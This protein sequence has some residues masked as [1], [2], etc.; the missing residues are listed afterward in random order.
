MDGLTI[1]LSIHRSIDLSLHG[2]RRFVILSAL[3]AFLLGAACSRPAPPKTF[4]LTGQVLSVD[5][6]KQLVTIRHEDIDGLMPGM[7]MSFPVTKP[8]LLD[9]REPGELVRGTLE[10]TDA[11][12]RLTTIERTGMSELPT[13]SNAA[14]MAGNLLDVG[15]TV[16]DAAFIDQANKRRSIAEWRGTATLMTFIYTQCPLPN[17][18]P[19][20]DQNF[21][22]LQT[23]IAGDV[24]LK[25]KAR[26]VSISFDPD[27]DT[28]DVLARHAARLQADPATWTFLTGDRATV[29]RFAARMGVGVM[30]EAGDPT[31]T[32]NL[33][34]IL[35]GTDGRVAKI[36][37]GSEWTTAGVIADLRAAA[38]RLP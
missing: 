28:P 22:K 18:C 1:D 19:L 25:A 6:E 31:I 36:Y 15:D 9:G 8:E 29:D 14:A 30:R 38:A 34:T 11:L 2:A 7:T 13:D 10:V 27:H 12:G 5:R 26:L 35:V 20:M 33:R 3:A 24:T 16:P 21:A 4:T 17:F 23:A 32:H 37:S